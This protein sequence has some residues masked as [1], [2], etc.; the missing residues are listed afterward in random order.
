M[1][2]KAGM[3]VYAV[4]FLLGILFVQQQSVLPSLVPYGVALSLLILLYYVYKIRVKTPVFIVELTLIITIICLIIFGIIYSSYHAHWQLSHRLDEGFVGQNIVLNGTVSN[5]PV[6]EGRV[7]R[8]QFSINHFQLPGSDISFESEDFFPKKI[9]LSW[10]YGRSLKA[11]ENWQLVVRLKPPHGFM[12]PGGFDYEAWLFQHGI[13]ATGYV[14]KSNLNRREAKASTGIDTFRQLLGASISEGKSDS[15][16]L[17]KALAIGDKSSISNTQWRVLTNTGT[18]HLMAISGLHIGLAALF[19]YSLIRRL[20]PVA[21][22]QRLPAQHISL[23]FGLIVAAMYALI[24]GLSIPTQRAIIMLTVLVLMTLVRRNHRPLDALGFA[25]LVVLLFDPLAVLSVGFWFSFSA[26]AVIFISLSPNESIKK[27]PEQS[28]LRFKVIQTLKQWVRLQLLISV[29]LLPLSLFMFQQVSLVSPLAN[30][31]L[32]PYVS[33]LVVPVV[34]MAIFS[35]LFLQSLSDMLFYIAATLLD[36]IWP[37][38]SMF[39]NLPHALLIKGDVSITQLLLTTVAMLLIYFS[40][41]LVAAIYIAHKKDAPKFIVWLFRAALCFMFVPIMFS[42]NTELKKNEF[43]LSVLDV[44]Q[45]SAAVIHTQNHTLVFDAGA[46]FSERLDAGRSVV[47]PYLR[48]QG[49]LKLD[50]LL[51][52]H[53]DADHIGGAQAIIDEYPD[54]QL[55]GQDIEQLHAQNKQ[56]CQQG[57]TWQWDGVSFTFLSPKMNKSDFNRNKRNDRSCVL[58]VRS[59]HGSVLLTGDIEKSAERALLDDYEDSLSSDIL[60]VPHH[61]SNTSSS[62]DFIRAVNPKISLI[63]AGYKNRYKLPASKVVA[64]YDLEHLKILTTAKSGAITIAITEANPLLVERYRDE[65]AKY[66]H[67]FGAQQRFAIS[68]QYR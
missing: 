56:I 54:V 53:G 32:I 13:D 33:F 64:R 21:M 10:Y 2:M 1:N 61:G 4:A 62:L 8:F 22:M 9:R 46:K 39:S 59:Q 50:R 27:S 68:R 24:A 66:W 38:L 55:V 17:I 11:G 41:H 49:I 43:I 36:F 5:I 37:L 58:Q 6:S 48:S 25:V 67:H 20:I 44:G 34:L 45:G 12:N 57:Q 63:S 28:S 31:L 14:R 26:V 47:I 16:A 7:Q 30:L 52:S 40:K 15:F 23:S 3:F 18:S 60:V 19:A 29:F 51:I 35:A 42:G 65:N